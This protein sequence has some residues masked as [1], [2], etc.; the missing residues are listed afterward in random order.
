MFPFFDTAY[1]GFCSGDLDKDAS[2]IRLFVEEK[3]ELFVAQSFAKNLGLYS[4]P[5]CIL[6]LIRHSLYIIVIKRWKSGK[7]NSCSK[8]PGSHTC[9]EVK[10]DHN[11]ERQL[12]EPTCSWRQNSRSHF[13][14][15]GPQWR[16][17]ILIPT[18]REKRKLF[19]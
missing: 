18:W 7:S 17:V 4:K 12:F 3:H 11:C 16:M 1:Q 13:Q 9:V 2:A 10:N 14:Q 15:Q 8:Q 19:N 6:V 5:I